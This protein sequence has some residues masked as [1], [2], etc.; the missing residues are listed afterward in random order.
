MLA[1]HAVARMLRELEF[2]WI[3]GVAGESF[4]PLLDGLRQEGLPFLQT[5]HE[6]GATFA[7][8]GHARA[9]GKP[10][11]VA[12]TR[13]PGA[14]N[15]FIGVHEAFQGETP[16]VVLVG[17]IE[18]GSRGRGALQEMEFTQVFA[19]AAKA[20]FEVTRSDQ[21]V[22]AILAAIRKSQ[23]GRP[24]PVIVSVPADLFFE[25]VDEDEVC[26]SLPARFVDS[27][28]LTDAE[29]ESITDSVVKARKGLII[30][31]QSF[32]QHRYADLLADFAEESGFGVLGGHAFLDVMPE[33]HSLFLGCST[34]RSSEWVSTALE[35]ADLLLFLDHRLG[36]RVTQTY[37]DIRGDII[38]I[39]SHLEVGWDE[40]LSAR[41]FASNP[42]SAVQQLFEALHSSQPSPDSDGRSAWVHRIGAALG[43]EKKSVLAKTCKEAKDTPDVVPFATLIEELH[44][45]LPTNANVVSDAGSFND[46]I[47][48]YLPFPPGR[49]YYGPL[50]GSMGF[51]VPAAIGVQ[52]GRPDSHTMVLVGDGGFLM[53][54]MELSTIARLGVNVTIAVLKN[55]IWGSIALHQDKDFPGGRFGV[56]LQNPNY[57]DLARS[58]GIEAFDVNAGCDLAHALTSAF[59]T[60]GPTL[61]QIPTDPRKPAPSCY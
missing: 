28:Q 23:L 19:S 1:G 41:F 57:A 51:A 24:G 52:L 14:A 16:L 56:D 27:G 40:Y 7:A 4:L 43:N 25:K 26:P 44:K 47:T 32:R 8:V 21:L 54:G 31:G 13:G 48:R 9:S 6:S 45:Q 29:V 59:Q 12:V 20:V 5:S 2:P 33:D 15:A 18:S 53:T 37:R 55:G 60:Q 34:I 38:A 22:T 30:V 10:G 58:F 3:S 11:I 39:S 46:W 61:I 50:S 42:V 17:Q 36:D 49:H 35:E